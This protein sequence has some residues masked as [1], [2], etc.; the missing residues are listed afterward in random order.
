[1]PRRYI[2]NLDVGEESKGSRCL[3]RR[4]GKKVPPF[5]PK[6]VDRPGRIS[7]RAKYGVQSLT[8]RQLP[9]VFAS[10]LTRRWGRR[11]WSHVRA[12]APGRTGAGIR[13][14][15]RAMVETA[16]RHRLRVGVFPPA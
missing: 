8:L 15:R 14:H 10:T 12:A 4:K 7:Y 9:T 5:K 3:G 13:F 6:M 11:F 16:D 2:C 1:M